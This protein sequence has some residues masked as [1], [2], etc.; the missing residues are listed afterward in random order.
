MVRFISLSSGSSGNC[1]YLGDESKAILIDVG[2]GGR[3]IKKRLLENELPIET[4]CAILITHDHF[5]HIKSVGT[6]AEKYSKP[7][8]TTHKI[9][10]ALENHICTRGRLSGLKQYL[11]ENI[12][13][14]INGISVTP[15]EVPHDATQTV[16]Y[17]INFDGLKV[18]VITDIG[19]VTEDAVKFAKQSDYLIAESNYDFDMLIS[20]F[21]PKEL[22]E[23]II[24]GHGHLSNE[25][26]SNL[27]KRCHHDTLQAIYLCHLSENNNT[28]SLAYMQAKETLEKLGSRASLE[29]LPRSKTSKMFI[30][31]TPHSESL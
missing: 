17:F 22:K 5:D 27:L 4:I 2:I 11:Q 10:K 16:G 25:Q 30:W 3:S 14:E 15:F 7:V 13:N 18:T 31:Q 26:N 23:R 29:C 1:Y 6:F 24:N 28:P 21:Y 20:G 19:S 8:F 9:H 12:A